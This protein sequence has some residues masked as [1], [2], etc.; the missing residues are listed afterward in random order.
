MAPPIDDTPP[1]SFLAGLVEVLRNQN[2]THGEQMRE[3]SS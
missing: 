2:R 1:D 3:M